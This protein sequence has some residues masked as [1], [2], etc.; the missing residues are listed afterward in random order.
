ML[1]ET[2]MPRAMTPTAAYRHLN[3][4]LWMGRLPHATVVRVTNATIPRCYGITVH[5]DIVVRPVILL[6]CDQAHVG[7]TLVHEMLHVA[8]PLL[9]HGDIFEALVNKYWNYARKNLK[10]ITS[11]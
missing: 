10:G 6:N 4:L 5:D 9:N 11:L 8:E 2:K 7:K 1:V 3:R